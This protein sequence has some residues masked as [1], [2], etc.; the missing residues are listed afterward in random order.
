M[1]DA[2]SLLYDFDTIFIQIKYQNNI[3]RTFVK[4]ILHLNVWRISDITMFI[5]WAQGLLS[6]ATFLFDRVFF[7][8]PT[9]GSS[10]KSDGKSGSFCTKA[11]TLGSSFWVDLWVCLLV[12]T[13]RVS[14]GR[15]TLVA[16]A[17]SP[18]KVDIKPIL[19]L[20]PGFWCW[21]YLIKSKIYLITRSEKWKIQKFIYENYKTD[22]F[23]E[24]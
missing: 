7:L 21:I 11:A 8:N 17:A 24:S 22:R 5:T 2:S 9:S 14:L 23:S 4:C 10:G 13:T 3:I 12:S 15:G 20:K 19:A 6:R 1:E 18:E 16:D